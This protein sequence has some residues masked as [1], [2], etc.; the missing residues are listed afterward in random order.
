MRPELSL[1]TEMTDFEYKYRDGTRFQ[2]LGT[3]HILYSKE[4]MDI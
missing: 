3:R 1:K 2:A 4:Y